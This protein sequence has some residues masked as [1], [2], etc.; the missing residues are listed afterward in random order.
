MW[1]TK[2]CNVIRKNQVKQETQ[3]SLTDRAKRLE[4][5]QG[6]K[7]WYH[8]RYGFLLVCYSNFVPKTRCF[9]DIRLQ[10]CSDLENRVK[11]SWRSLKIS[12]FDTEHDFLLMFYSCISCLFFWDIQ[13]RKYIATL[14]FRSTV[15]Q[16]HW[17][18]YHSIGMVRL[19][20]GCREAANCRY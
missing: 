3:L 11:G 18:W 8:S 7:T 12:P 19:P 17:K 2:K 10:K 20:A 9:W 6:H 1:P 4:V 13:C 15:N 5:S 16:G 14:K